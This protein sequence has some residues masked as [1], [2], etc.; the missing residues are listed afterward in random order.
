[1][2]ISSAQHTIYSMP[3]S[4]LPQGPECNFTDVTPREGTFNEVDFK[5]TVSDCRDKEDDELAPEVEFLGKN[6]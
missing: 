5:L 6:I 4:I 2:E 1:M 3:L